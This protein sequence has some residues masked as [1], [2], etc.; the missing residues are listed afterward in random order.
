MASVQV[1]HDVLQVVHDALQ[2]ITMFYK[3]FIM[4]HYVLQCLVSCAT[5]GIVDCV[6]ANCLWDSVNAT[7]IGDNY[8]EIGNKAAGISGIAAKMILC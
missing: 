2:C 1:F 7:G 5:I 4:F 3:C 8:A 6:A